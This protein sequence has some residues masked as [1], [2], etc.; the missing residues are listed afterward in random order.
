MVALGWWWVG[1]QCGGA[2]AE[3]LSR[4]KGRGKTEVIAGHCFER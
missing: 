4:G 3:T 1:Q 2:L